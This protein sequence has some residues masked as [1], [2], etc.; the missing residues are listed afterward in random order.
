MPRVAR[1]SSKGWS[2]ISVETTTRP[3]ASRPNQ[4]RA[5]R[6]KE[7]PVRCKAPKGAHSDVSSSHPQ[8][9]S[10][11]ANV[12]PRTRSRQG[13]RVLPPPGEPVGAAPSA[14]A[15][16]PASWSCGYP[17]PSSA[18]CR[19][20]H[21]HQQAG[22]GRILSSRFFVCWRTGKRIHSPATT[23]RRRKKE[24][25]ARSGMSETCSAPAPASWWRCELEAATAQGKPSGWHLRT[26][27]DRVARAFDTR[28]SKLARSA[29]TQDRPRLPASWAS[30]PASKAACPSS[31]GL[32]N[33][34]PAI[35]YSTRKHITGERVVSYELLGSTLRWQAAAEPSREWRPLCVTERFCQQAGVHVRPSRVLPNR[36]RTGVWVVVP[37]ASGSPSGR[38]E[39]LVLGL[40][41]LAT[42][43]M[44]SGKPGRIGPSQV[45]PTPA[46]RKGVP[47]SRTKLR[48]QP[49][50]RPLA[51]QLRRNKP[52][53]RGHLPASWRAAS[54]S[55]D[56]A[57]QSEVLGRLIP[58]VRAGHG[59]PGITRT[60]WS[61][62]ISWSPSRHLASQVSSR[63]PNWSSFMSSLPSTASRPANRM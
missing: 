4:Q 16:I 63:S 26:G 54:R 10:R 3:R 41:S 40:D 49:E 18:R 58:E 24:R 14:V 39:Y 38:S 2:M 46:S 25:I 21:L 19:D 28:A 23:G 8:P 62:M 17:L 30:R 11:T 43:P 27:D 47:P 9:A 5:V 31:E 15:A 53:V 32:R 52:E 61:S 7:G 55:D 33:T 34:H 50:S 20:S 57:P 6:T 36:R 51:S 44:L 35:R 42:G 48:G 1:S 13:L 37:M 22:F 59:K 60:S 29:S 56:T 45:A 12:D